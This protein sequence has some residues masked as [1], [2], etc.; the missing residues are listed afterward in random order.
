MSKFASKYGKSTHIH[1]YIAQKSFVW[2]N[3]AIA[4]VFFHLHYISSINTCYGYARL[5]MRIRVCVNRY[6][7]SHHV[8]HHH[9]IHIHRHRRRSHYSAQTVGNKR[10]ICYVH[11]I[12]LSYKSSQHDLLEIHFHWKACNEKI[13]SLFFRQLGIKLRC[14]TIIFGSKLSFL[15][16]RINFHKLTHNKKNKID[17]FVRLNRICSDNK[18]NTIKVENKILQKIKTKHIFAAHFRNKKKVCFCFDF[19]RVHMFKVFIHSRMHK[20]CVCIQWFYV[21]LVENLLWCIQF[22]FRNLVFSPFGFE[23][24][25]TLFSSFQNKEQ[26]KQVCFSH[27]LLWLWL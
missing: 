6:M 1:R 15:I 20:V 19:V 24:V 18:E 16:L 8:Y 12:F 10:L 13:G 23:S 3:E 14:G 17:F 11:N 25:S 21:K 22:F 9:R 27:N 2:R 7:R 4:M 26:K 5:C